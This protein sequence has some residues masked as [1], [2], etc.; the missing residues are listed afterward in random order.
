MY[1]DA[2]ERHHC[3]ASEPRLACPGPSHRMPGLHPCQGQSAW[4]LGGPSS[5]EEERAG[6]RGASQGP[7]TADSG[8][9]EAG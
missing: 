1:D 3:A 4:C 7:A 5:E 9:C 8:G 2:A 6:L